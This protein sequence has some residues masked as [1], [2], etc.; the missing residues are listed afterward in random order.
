MKKW[1]TIVCVTCLAVVT[2]HGQ[3]PLTVGYQKTQQLPVPGATAAYSLDSDIVEASAANGV[4]AIAGKRPG[5]THIVVVTAAGIQT[6]AVTVSAP[7]SILPPGAEPA[8]REGSAAENGTYEVRYS[9]DPKQLTNALTMKRTEG[10]SFQRLQAVNANLFTA[11][12]GQSRVGF[13]LASYEIR[14]PGRDVVLID[15][16]V[17]NSPLTVNRSMVRGLHLRQGAWQFHG[18]FTTIATFQGLFLATDPETTLG[19]SRTFG[20]NP[21]HGP[22][23]D[24]DRQGGLLADQR[25][26]SL[27]AS[28]YY[29]KNPANQAA[30]A[31]D[32]VVGS[33]AYRIR[34]GDKA[35]LLSELGVSRGAALALRGRYETDKSH[36]MG[37]FRIEPKR[38]ASLAV[39]TQHGTFADVNAAHDFSERLNATLGLTQSNYNLPA[40][41][42]DTFTSN[43]LLNYKLAA[44]VTVSGGSAFS[45]FSSQ[46]PATAAIET[47]NLPAGIDY[48]AR[49]FGA[50]FQ[51]QRTIN[52]EGS[53]GN[54]FGVNARSTWGQFQLGGFYRHDVDVPT[55]AAIFTQLPGLQDLLERAGIVVTSPDQL[56]Q[57]LRDTALL[58]SLGF[59][60]PLSVNLAPSRDS[61]GASL[62][63]IGKGASR[64]QVNVSYYDSET[65]LIQGNLG[66]TSV[67]TS[68]S[69][70]LTNSDDL[71]VSATM[72]RSV[73]NGRST[74]RPLVSLSLQHRFYSVP[75]FILPGRHGVIEG[76]V[77]RD[78][79]SEG[80]YYQQPALGGVE[81]VLDDGR[82]THSDSTG[83]YSFHHVPFGVHRVKARYQS[84]EPFF[85]TTDSP[86]VA[87]MNSTVDFGINFAKGQVFGFVLNDAGKGV[88][89][90][91]VEIRA[92]GFVRTVLTT[93]DGKFSFLGLES[94]AYNVSTRPESYPMGYSLQ[95]L[96]TA[97]V[98][99]EP[100][101]PAKAELSVKAIR[102][103][104]GRVAIYDRASGRQ[105][106]LP[107]ATVTLKEL[108]LQAVTS[109]TGAYI[110][111][112]LP[113]GRYTIGV[114]WA[115]KETSSSVVVPADPANIKG[116]DLNAGSR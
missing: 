93:A 114:T 48:S 8:A 18:G 21:N 10:D 92:T 113:A 31:P 104:S 100:G 94:G 65:Q 36:L 111:R 12:S 11:S 88:A 109:A 35:S 7:R 105:V 96:P 69:Q 89:G 83:H 70:R 76:H 57:L 81:I 54:D 41:R 98:K 50:G 64:R 67:T 91:A 72:F 61:W 32:G 79:E 116:V 53:G 110:F 74:T 107:G 15:D 95:S 1:L 42:Q 62:G 75:S 14:R 45:H 55:L 30:V 99:V 16:Q 115:G 56:A 33:L 87:A 85:Y 43:F 103:V 44:K 22:A 101:S 49:H 84:V 34:Y 66:F 9:S 20:R 51:Y 97:E 28:L 82:V 106:P 40:L 19:I 26:S 4:V 27:T 60:N 13:P 47:L 58:S 78:D 23:V 63:W 52:F 46:V 80:H 68:Y 86:A 6:F 71:V 77:F 90:V 5:S 39:N 59:T 38:F 3:S 102:A 2:A 25:S 108:S 37:N 112:N 17:D 24:L 73:D 29:F